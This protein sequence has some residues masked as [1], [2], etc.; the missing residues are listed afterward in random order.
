MKMI[1]LA[2]ASCRTQVIRQ[3]IGDAV[4]GAVDL[5]RYE[6]LPGGHLERPRVQYSPGLVVLQYLIRPIAI[7]DSQRGT[8][9]RDRTRSSALPHH[10]AG[11]PSL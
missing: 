9:A 6:E 3:C 1:K 4:A 5:L 11:L 2:V 7:Q 8:G 10:C